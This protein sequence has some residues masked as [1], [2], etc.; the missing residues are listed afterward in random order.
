M[1]E[2][3]EA[4]RARLAELVAARDAEA[5][6]ITRLVNVR[7]LTGLASSNAALLVRADGTAVLATDGRYAG[8]AARVCPELECVVDRA[9]AGALT[10]RAA[11][12]LAFEAHA[13]TVE[14]HDELAAEPGAPELVPLGHA[15]EELR[16][17]KDEEE[18]ALLREACAITDQAFDAV[19]P[20]IRPGVTERAIAI[21]LDRAMID[22]GA[23]QPA[24]AT[25]VASGPNGAIPHHVPSGRAIEHGDLVTM[26]FGALQGGYHADMT[27]TIAVGA[28][29]A[30]EREIY[31]LVAAAQAA[32]LAAARPDAVTKEVDAAA[33]GVIEA[34]GH[35]DEFPHGLGH[36]V[37]LE[38]HEA[39]LMG[40]DKTGKLTDRVPITVEPG[41]YVAGRG[42]V[43][44]ED[45][46][47]VRADGPELLTKTT[48]DLLVS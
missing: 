3:H 44:I 47:V 29:G 28:A 18:I 19:L 2:I 38:I 1:P 27:R 9:T 20:T 45:T 40:Y 7:Y 26:D 41:V 13:V 22:L 48:K 31:A 36:G 46:L 24:F 16:M 34:A 35:G 33:R 10:A 14:A 25:I 23:E 30:W 15:V 12:R 4:R 8:T 39:P 5:A 6:L 32:G 21:A 43:R 11:G 42:G 37:G 17:V